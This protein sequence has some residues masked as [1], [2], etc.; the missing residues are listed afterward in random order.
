M[1]LFNLYKYAAVAAIMIVAHSCGS[2]DTGGYKANWQP[3]GQ[4]YCSKSTDPAKAADESGPY[5]FY[6]EEDKNASTPTYRNVRDASKD[7]TKCAV[8]YTP[9]FKSTNISTGSYVSFALYGKDRVFAA[10]VTEGI[11]EYV[12]GKW[13]TPLGMS[14]AVKNDIFYA[15]MRQGANGKFFIS[16]SKGVYYQAG[17][18]VYKQATSP[19]DK[20]DMAGALGGTDKNFFV[21][22]GRNFR[23]IYKWDGVSKFVLTNQVEGCFYSIEALDDNNV[24][25]GSHTESDGTP[26]KTYGI[27]RYNGSSIVAIDG[28]KDGS[29]NLATLN[30]KMYAVGGGKVYL[31]NG[32]T[33]NPI[34]EKGGTL[35]VTG[36]A[37]Y[38]LT[39]S[40]V[41]VYDETAKT[42]TS[43][44]PALTGIYYDIVYSDGFT[45]A[46]GETGVKAYA[47]NAW[48]NIST[49]AT[50]ITTGI[51][52]TPG[53]FMGG[54]GNNKGIQ[55]MDKVYN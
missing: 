51:A 7:N 31:W 38:L 36:G 26:G 39:A 41:L 54:L 1:K 3:T 37:L 53:L 35:R 46:F 5:F 44:K 30:N 10:G 32:T 17:D 19:W 34:Y 6:Q 45:Y 13:D 42:F 48:T 27:R 33:F 8:G 49:P 52:S 21:S 29:Y 2:D 12:N 9:V 20:G 23:G 40:E 15:R 11:L 16:T 24:F 28:F 22:A 4:T 25:F 55:I 47:N 14:D 18:N 50:K 43:T